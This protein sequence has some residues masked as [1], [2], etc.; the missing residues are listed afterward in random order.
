M[1][2]YLYSAQPL[3]MKTIKK[4]R[5]ILLSYA[6]TQASEAGFRRAGVHGSVHF[7]L[8][9][10]IYNVW[11]FSAQCAGLLSLLA[12]LSP[13]PAVLTGGDGCLALMQTKQ[14]SLLAFNLHFV[15]SMCISLGTNPV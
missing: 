5:P 12:A 10:V 13:E 8:V 7:E 11:R 4:F 1:S 3:Y 2:F 6:K 15:F 9:T 14:I